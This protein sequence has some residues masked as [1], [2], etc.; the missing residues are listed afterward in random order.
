MYSPKSSL[1]AVT[2]LSTLAISSFVHAGGFL[3]YE[4][5]ARAIALGGTLVARGGDA[6]VLF[7]NPAGLS[8]LKGTHLSLGTT[9]IMRRGNF[10]GANPFPG[11]G[12]TEEYKNRVHF[13]PNFYISRQLSE[14]LSAGFAVFSPFGLDVQWQDEVRFSGRYIS[15]KTIFRSF[16]FNPTIAYKLSPDLSIAAG[17]QAVSAYVELNRFNATPIN[18]RIYDTAKV[19]LSGSNGLQI[20]FN[21]GMLF[22]VI[23]KLNFG[24]AYRS[25]V[26]IEIGDGKAEF[27]QIRI[28]PGIDPAVAASLPKNQRAVT[29]TRFPAIFSLGLGY[30]ATEK[31]DVA[32]D[33]VFTEWSAFDRV[34]IEFPE[35]P[36]LNETRSEKWKDTWSYRFGAQYQWNDRLALRA[37]YS[38]DLTPQ[39]Q[40]SM[41]P[42]LADA[43]RHDMS[44]GFGYSLNDRLTL[45]VANMFTFF[46]KQSTGGLSNDSFNGEYRMA[47]Y[48]LGVSFSYN[49]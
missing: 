40:A 16:Y 7:Y 47:A 30:R 3:I 21:A 25:E 17:L 43:N 39:P 9:L 18:G 46:E 41:S 20:G 35:T 34:I 44:F 36:S 10:A 8:W 32:F 15:H 6:S 38:R 14:N 45:D 28:D 13:P 37:G 2:I 27:N 26:Q 4:H 24:L 31:L 22:Q 23:H 42:L 12:I 33:A 48:V 11:F 19:K 49:F 1:V 29:T 5:G